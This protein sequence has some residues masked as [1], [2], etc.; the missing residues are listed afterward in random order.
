LGLVY[1]IKIKQ[2]PAHDAFPSANIS[3]GVGSLCMRYLL[4]KQRSLQ[5]VGALVY[6]LCGQPQ[7]PVP[8]GQ[9]GRGRS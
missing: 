3:F 4:A 6:P 1:T 7:A 9:L 8:I 2:Q 5:R